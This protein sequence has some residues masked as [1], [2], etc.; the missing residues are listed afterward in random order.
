M[1][2]GT[3]QFDFALCGRCDNVKNEIRLEV[4]MLKRLNN[5]M[6]NSCKVTILAIF[7]LSRNSSW[8]KI[9]EQQFHHCGNRA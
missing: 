4:D 6:L 1:A 2:G 8:R 5:Y 3:Q 7:P 9:N